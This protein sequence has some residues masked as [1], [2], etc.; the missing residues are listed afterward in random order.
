MLRNGAVLA[1]LR[2][3]VRR[4]CVVRD[5]GSAAG[6]GLLQATDQ[7][8]GGCCG[9]GGALLCSVRVLIVDVGDGIRFDGRRCVGVGG[10]VAAAGLLM[11]TIA[12]LVVGGFACAGGGGGDGDVLVV[13]ADGMCFV[14]VYVIWG[15]GGGGS[16]LGERAQQRVAS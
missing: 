6:F 5:A 4:R 15:E 7:T 1:L 2:L 8:D 14:W 3:F 9:G 11:L 13:P 16:V 10:A 12:L